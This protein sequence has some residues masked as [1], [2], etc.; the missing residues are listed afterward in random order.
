MISEVDS[1]L[2]T[3]KDVL[4]SID[5]HKASISAYEK[6]LKELN[7]VYAKEAERDEAITSLTQ[8]VDGIQSALTRLEILL[9][10]HENN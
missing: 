6:I 9:T 2:K 10:R 5:K 3:S 4:D 1:L 8:Q 7:P